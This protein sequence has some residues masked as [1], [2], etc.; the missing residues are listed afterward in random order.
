ML[1]FDDDVKKWRELPLTVKGLA[2]AEH[3][4]VLRYLSP[5][6]DTKFML[7]DMNNGSIYRNAS[8]PTPVRVGVHM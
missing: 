8:V 1:L 6:M 3:S 7:L 2:H 4:P 5:S